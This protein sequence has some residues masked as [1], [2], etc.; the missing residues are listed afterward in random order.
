M[1]DLEAYEQAKQ[2]IADNLELQP[3]EG[4]LS[5]PGIPTV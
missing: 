1:T 3:F 4:Y 2:R 5:Y